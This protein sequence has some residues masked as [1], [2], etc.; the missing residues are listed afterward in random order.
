MAALVTRL[1]RVHPMP[2]SLPVHDSARADARASGLRYF[3]DEH[4][5]LGRR[6]HGPRFA[7]V[8]AEGHAIGDQATLKRIRHLAIPPAWSDV[9][10]SPVANG[11]IQATGRD[12]RG[13]KQYRYHADF[14]AARDRTKYEHVL[15]FGE[16]L[17]KVRARV[18]SDMARRGLPREKVLATVV[19]L[20]DT[21]L[22]RV[23]N[24]EYARDNHS[25]GLTTLEDRHVDV[26]GD[27][28]RF[29]F[30]G[31]SGKMWRL[32][33]HDRR[34]ARI[35]KSCQELPGQH[36]FQYLD[37]S[38]AQQAVESADVN[39][40][41][42]EITGA[43]I[44]AKDFRTFAGT[45]LAAVELIGF[46]P[47]ASAT[48]AKVNVRA[49]VEAVAKRLGNTPAICRKCYIHPEIVAA[50]LDGALSLRPGRDSATIEGSERAVLRFLEARIA[51]KPQRRRKS[52]ATPAHIAPVAAAAEVAL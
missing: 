29:E 18:E 15:A 21:T 3:S 45:V 38:G 34:V 19:R 17:A 16:V 1:Q 43:E 52:S 35:V 9:W 37:E 4:P 31:K 32:K 47:F 33:L 28:L 13:R 40:Y 27:A 49:A 25:F 51:P 8:D 12:A 5:G 2:D 11:H 44:T 46:K 7:Y 41:L 14:R 30:K 23:G 22:I 6:R 24:S 39:A 42:H 48:E 36:L 26:A 10:I 50:Y 20:L